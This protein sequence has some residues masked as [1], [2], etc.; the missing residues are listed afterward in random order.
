MTDTIYKMNIYFCY[1]RNHDCGCYVAADTIGKAKALYAKW[2]G[3]EDFTEYRGYVM[4]K[5][6]DVL[7]GVYDED[8]PELA[9]WGVRVLLFRRIR[10][11]Q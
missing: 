3:M 6:V 7:A 11:N 9:R 10:S 1:E 2:D 4:R 5:G 8:C